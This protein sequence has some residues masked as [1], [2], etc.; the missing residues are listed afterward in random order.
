MTTK[1]RTIKKELRI[2]G[3][4]DAPFEFKG[5]GTTM[6]IGTVYRA[7]NWPD[8]VLS[9]AIDVD[10]TDSTEKIIEMVNSSR[11]K[12]QLRVIMLDGIT[13][14]GMNVVDINSVYKK[15]KLPVIIVNRKYPDYDSIRKALEN[16]EDGKQRFDK[17]KKAGKMH[18]IKVKEHKLYIQVAGIK[19]ED[20]AEIVRKSS[21]R[22]HIPEPL[23]VSHLIASGV[24]TGESKGRA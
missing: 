3:I 23:R 20:A 17:I 10:G 22:S 4:D 5:T 7:G 11:H 12:D 14:G 8:G 6:L 2:L 21:T 18:E 13:F 19:L 1:F 16:F 15:T 24:T 9:R